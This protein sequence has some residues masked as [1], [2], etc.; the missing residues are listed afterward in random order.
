MKKRPPDYI[1]DPA[2]A[3]ATAELKRI[4][5]QERVQEKLPQFLDQLEQSAVLPRHERMEKA[6]LPLWQALRDSAVEPERECF[7]RIA[8]CIEILPTSVFLIRQSLK[9]FR[10]G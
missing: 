3:D 1:N 4:A 5:R 7:G 6:I 2:D 10:N 8:A 9:H